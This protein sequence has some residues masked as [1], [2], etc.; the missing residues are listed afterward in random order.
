[1]F[2][3]H[4]IYNIQTQESYV[5]IFMRFWTGPHIVVSTV[6]MKMSVPGVVELMEVEIEIVVTELTV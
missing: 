1:M 3:T 6:S 2:K 5:L 4:I